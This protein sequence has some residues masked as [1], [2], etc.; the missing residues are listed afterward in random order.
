[1]QV[2]AQLNYSTSFT[3]RMIPYSHIMV[4][5]FK[6][7]ES[8]STLTLTKTKIVHA[9]THS[10]LKIKKVFLRLVMRLSVK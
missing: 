9:F 6:V 1:M 3:E 2:Q 5:S 7:P 8:I 4:Y 10:L